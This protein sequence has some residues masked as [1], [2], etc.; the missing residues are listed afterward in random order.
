MTE[1]Q[2]NFLEIYRKNLGN[3]T[4]TCKKSGVNSRQTYYNWLAENTEF[5]L[6]IDEIQ[7]SLLDFVESQ[8]MLLIRGV[9]KYKETKHKDG[10]VTRD[11]VG[12]IDRPDRNLIQFYLQTKGKGRGYV[13]RR[14]LEVT[15]PEAVRLQQLSDDE[16]ANEVKELFD[17]TVSGQI[18]DGKAKG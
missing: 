3:I 16:L 6:A 7:E 13:E 1:N 9:P 10:S 17:R 8:Q 4:E 15:T 18:G 5:K 11:F 14:E 2:L 12:W